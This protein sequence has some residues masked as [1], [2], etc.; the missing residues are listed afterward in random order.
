[1]RTQM[2]VIDGKPKWNDFR[3]N[4]ILQY[5]E[6]ILVFV[7]RN[8]STRYKQTI[9]GPAWL[10]I[11]PLFTVFAYSI[12]FGGIAGLSTDGVPKPLFY[13]LGSILWNL[14]SGIVSD[15]ANTFTSNVGL[16]GK[17]YFPRL[18]VPISNAI[19]KLV[20]FFIQLLLFLC[21]YIFYRINGHKFFLESEVF[22]CFVVVCQFCLLGLGIVIIIS[23]ITTKYRDLTVLVGF[24]LQ[25]WLYASPVIYSI[26]IVPERLIS[27]YYLN[28]IVPGLLIF[29]YA[30]LGIGSIPYLSWFISWIVTLVILLTG[31]I[32]FN[33]VEKDFMDVI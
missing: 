17:V 27:L 5:R 28:P 33:H 9:L 23:S 1:M 13:L 24:G 2:I 19:T 31:L 15:T 30:F 8:F 22:L 14:F 4:E 10:I 12:V 26:S 3:L 21:V 20:D 25:I 32:L 11:S 16:F 6:T 18:V 29:R 7:K